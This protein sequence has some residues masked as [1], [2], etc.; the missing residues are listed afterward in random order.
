MNNNQ[1]LKKFP[2]VLTEGLA[3][4]VTF[5]NA[6]KFTQ[7]ELKDVE[8]VSDKVTNF[9][10]DEIPDDRSIILAKAYCDAKIIKA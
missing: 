9:F 7:E 2:S 5:L 1:T 10:E 8:Y 4:L 3:E 6:Q